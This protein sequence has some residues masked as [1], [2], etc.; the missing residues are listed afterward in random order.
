MGR[1]R[2]SKTRMQSSQDSGNE[3]LLARVSAQDYDHVQGSDDEKHL[4]DNVGHPV[5]HGG[6]SG[7]IPEKHLLGQLHVGTL[8][9]VIVLRCLRQPLSATR[10]QRSDCCPQ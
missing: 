6:R 3:I 9:L 4:D 5:P 8:H 7:G 2:A 1:N 10:A